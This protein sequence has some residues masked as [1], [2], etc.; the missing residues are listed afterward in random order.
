MSITQ[1]MYVTPTTP[2]AL[3]HPT[4]PTS[5]HTPSRPTQQEPA[6]QLPHVRLNTPTEREGK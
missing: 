5:F 6:S 2:V 3:A 4:V 1:D